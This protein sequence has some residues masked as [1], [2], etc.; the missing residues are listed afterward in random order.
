MDLFFVKESPFSDL[1]IAKLN[2]AYRHAGKLQ[3]FHVV[4]LTHPAD[5]SVSA[6]K[7]LKRRNSVS[8][9]AANL[10]DF[11]GHS[12]SSVKLDRLAQN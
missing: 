12:S 6:L 7:K 3:D 8:V 5:L 4:S 10:P 1:Q 11:H 9:F 2:F